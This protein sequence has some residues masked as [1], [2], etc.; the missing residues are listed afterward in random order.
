LY[1]FGGDRGSDLRAARSSACLSAPICGKRVDGFRDALQID[2]LKMELS[3]NQL[4][5]FGVALVREVA[6][7]F[8]ELRVA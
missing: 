7:D 6:D 2:S 1:A 8:E 4:V 5:R 3:A